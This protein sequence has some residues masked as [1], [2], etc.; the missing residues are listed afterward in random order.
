MI[1]RTPQT[2][3]KRRWDEAIQKHAMTETRD[4]APWQTAMEDRI[5]WT[6]ME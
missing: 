5:C 3:G 1:Q 6:S 2:L 4:E